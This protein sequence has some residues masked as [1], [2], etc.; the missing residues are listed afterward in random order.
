MTLRLSCYKA[1]KTVLAVFSA[2]ILH[3]HIAHTLMAV[4]CDVDAPYIFML[5][6][7][8]QVSYLHG[9]RSGHTA[10]GFTGEARLMIR[11]TVIFIIA[12]SCTHP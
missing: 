2:S 6:I 8:L 3:T 5:A 4:Y 10:Q 12:P 7:P 1:K 9:G 11:T